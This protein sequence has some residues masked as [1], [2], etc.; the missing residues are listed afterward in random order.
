MF[1]GAFFIFFSAFCTFPSAFCTS[2]ADI[3]ATGSS[4]ASAHVARVGAVCSEADSVWTETGIGSRL[5]RFLRGM[6][7]WAVSVCAGR[8]ALCVVPAAATGFS[9][10]AAGRVTALLLSPMT[11]KPIA[12]TAAAAGMVQNH[13]AESFLLFSGA[14]G[15][16]C[17]CDIFF[18]MSA[19][20]PCG[21]VSSLFSRRERN[22]SIHSS[23]IAALFA[24]CSR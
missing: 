1:C 14:Y 17:C 11:N 10:S 3:T 22:F 21:G 12:T 6:S 24:F 9:P 23:F 15:A 2:G 16:F 8:V 4:A 7:V 5:M 13:D 18:C 20:S 19:N